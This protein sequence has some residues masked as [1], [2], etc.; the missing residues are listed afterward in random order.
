MEK[1]SLLYVARMGRDELMFT[2]GGRQSTGRFELCYI[3]FKHWRQRLR[4]C[5]ESVVWF[6]MCEKYDK[7]SK[8]ETAK[9]VYTRALDKWGSK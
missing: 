7:F 3:D 6:E 1:H 9:A 5:D 4:D 8:H 2:N